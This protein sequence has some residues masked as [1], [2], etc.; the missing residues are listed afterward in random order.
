M[1]TAMSRHISGL[2]DAVRKVGEIL[3]ILISGSGSALKNQLTE[4]GE[5]D[6]MIAG[7]PDRRIAGSRIASPASSARDCSRPL[8]SPPESSASAGGRSDTRRSASSSDS[9]DL[10]PARAAAGSRPAPRN[11]RRGLFSALLGLPLLLGLA[12]PTAAQTHR[13]LDIQVTDA[14]EGE[15]IIV[16]L[17]LSSAPGSVSVAERTF[18]VST[19]VP[20]RSGQRLHRQP[21]LHGRQHAC[22]G[23][24]FH[25]PG[26]HQHRCVRRKRDSKDR[27]HCHHHRQPQRRAGSGE[28]PL[29]ITSGV[30]SSLRRRRSRW[31]RNSPDEMHSILPRQ[32]FQRL[33]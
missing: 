9:F 24:G 28:D 7:S 21:W 22:R 4:S 3:F 1:D 27:L 5:I 25:R 13:N 19:E 2:M 18:T 17:T 14:Y 29:T 10:S 15:N 12:A 6:I 26:Q 20:I 32:C 31:A 23:N 30:A 8:A 16:T 33:C 11:L